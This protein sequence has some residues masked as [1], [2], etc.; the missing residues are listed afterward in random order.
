MPAIADAKASSS[1]TPRR[2]QAQVD[3]AFGGQAGAVAV[4][5]K[6]LG[7]AA[8]DADLAQRRVVLAPGIGPAP[9]LCCLAGGGGVQ[10]HQWQFGLQ[11]GDQ[12]ARWQHLVHAPAIGGAH[13]HVF[14]KAQ[15]RAGAAK[16]TCHGQNLL[17]VGAALDHHV[18]LDAAEA[19]SVRRL[20]AG[21]HV[22]HRKV[23]VVHR[24][25]HRVVQTIEAHGDAVQARV[26]ERACLARQQR[27]VGRQGQVGRRAIQ[28]AQFSQLGNE[29]LEVFAQQRLA[30]GEA[31]LAD[32][33]GQELPRQ[34]G[35]LFKAQQ[36]VVRQVGVV[37][38][39]NFLGH[40][41]VA[42]EVAAVGD[43]D[44]QVAQRAAQRIGQ[45]TGH[46]REHFLHIGQLQPGPAFINQGENT[47]FSHAL[48]L[49]QPCCLPPA[50]DPDHAM[51]AG[52]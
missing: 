14:D 24:T 39:K 7:D 22:G 5:A 2:K 29:R 1:A 25:K 49:P 17:V 43:A 36:R 40:A 9:A 37:L 26:L 21:E 52:A 19:H 11:A 34:P 8:D 46:H 27:S 12:F 33:M 31:D 3:L 13:V 15:R 10:R 16:M 44:A 42:A 51:A 30:S 18:D 47:F 23:D 45:P 48:I 50:T 28:S 4:L 6:R 35:D 32:P 41:V 20:D 38:V